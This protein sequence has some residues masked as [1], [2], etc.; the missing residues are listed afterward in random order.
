MFSL[1]LKELIFYF[2]LQRL[3]AYGPPALLY[4][5]TIKQALEKKENDYAWCQSMMQ[6]NVTF[7]EQETYLKYLK[8]EGDL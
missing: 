3:V 8:H 6:V 1:L 2:Y 4:R 5:M 7:F